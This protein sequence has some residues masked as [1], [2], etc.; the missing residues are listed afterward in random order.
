ADPTKSNGFNLWKC[1]RNIKRQPIRKIPIKKSDDTWCRSDTEISLAFADELEKRFQPFDLANPE[2][3]EE[4]LAFINAPSPE[5]V[6]IQHVSPEEVCLHIRKLHPNKAPG[7]DGIDSRIAKALPKKGILFLV[8][9]FNSMLRIHHFP[10]QWKCAVIT[11]IPKPGKPENLGS[12][13]GPVLYTLFTSDLPSPNGPGTLL[14]TYA[15]DTAF[16]V[17][18]PCRNEAS[19]ITQEFLDSYGKW[20]NRW[21]ISINNRKSQHC[22]FT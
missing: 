13:L 12:V 20:T 1:T 21:N 4:T 14:A 19:R 5:A 15:D 11:M 9:L 18:S 6:P 8:L 17:N 2:D 3:V 22:N 10:S 7:F 16:L